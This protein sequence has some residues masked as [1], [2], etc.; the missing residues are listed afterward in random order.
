MSAF[1]VRHNYLTVSV[2]MKPQTK[3][4]WKYV[5]T[6][7]RAEICGWADYEKSVFAKFGDSVMHF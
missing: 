4:I 1:E 3:I 5:L 2:S 6:F 7:K